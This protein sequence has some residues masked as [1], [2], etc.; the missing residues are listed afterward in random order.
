[1]IPDGN[2][3]L[4]KQSMVVVMS[5]FISEDHRYNP[6]EDHRVS[7]VTF[8]RDDYTQLKMI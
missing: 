8:W 1:M 3:I 7:M 6:R 4:L 2:V 5:C